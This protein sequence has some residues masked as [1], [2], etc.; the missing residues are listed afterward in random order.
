LA[1]QEETS[2]FLLAWFAES[3]D[4]DVEDLLSK[5]NLKYHE[6]NEHILTLASNH[7]SSPLTF[8]QDL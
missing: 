5:D 4:N 6:A 2:D 1:Y 7:R 3:H 8:L